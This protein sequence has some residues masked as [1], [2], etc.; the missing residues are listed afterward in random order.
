[1]DMTFD[2]TAQRYEYATQNEMLFHGLG[3][4]VDFVRTIGLQKILDHNK[5]LAEKF[6]EGLKEIPGIEVISPEENEYRTAMI[7]FRVKEQNIREI[8]HELSNKRGIRVR[9]VPEVGLE[10]LRVSFHV[11]NNESEVERILRE[12]K[13]LVNGE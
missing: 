1:M 10:G 2:P 5:S 12:L 8:A 6:Y 4:G 9:H 3:A 13:T 11:Y 7:T